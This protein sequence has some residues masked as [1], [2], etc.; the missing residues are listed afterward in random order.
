LGKSLPPLIRNQFLYS[1][2]EEFGATDLHAP[3]CKE[4]Q[5]S[6]RVSLQYCIGDSSDW[7]PVLELTWRAQ[8]GKRHLVVS[9]F[10]PQPDRS[11]FF[12]KT[13]LYSKL[14]ETYTDP[15]KYKYVKQGYG[16]PQSHPTCTKGLQKKKNYKQIPAPYARRSFR[17]TPPP[18]ATGNWP[19]H[20]QG[21]KR[22]PSHEGFEV[23]RRR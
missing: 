22:T 7:K 21:P 3:W 13:Y 10:R 18:E 14:R 20:A 6:E 12:D 11:F 5:V 16:R 17:R 9:V 19:P 4:S 8:H 15:Y 23:S 1:T 2:V